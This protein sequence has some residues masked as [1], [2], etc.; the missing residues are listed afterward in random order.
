M[1]QEDVLAQYSMSNECYEL[2]IS[3]ARPF[4]TYYTSPNK[5]DVIN[6]YIPW[7]EVGCLQAIKDVNDG[8]FKPV[9][10]F[11]V[12]TDLSTG[13]N[14]VLAKEYNDKDPVRPIFKGIFECIAIMGAY[15]GDC[16]EVVLDC[17]AGT[18]GDRVSFYTSGG[19]SSSKI[20]AL[21]NLYRRDKCK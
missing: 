21:L 4:S 10:R 9:C 5:N 18:D 11:P 12:T 15:H 19:V 3:P 14:G 16:K 2:D 17:A 7:Y 8:M 1:T 6:K 20:N 13:E